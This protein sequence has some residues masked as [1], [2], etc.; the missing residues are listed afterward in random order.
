[1]NARVW[2]PLLIIALALA[3]PVVPFLL[4]GEQFE[5]TVAAWLS[6]EWSAAARFGAIVLVLAV[7]LLLP[8]PS[9]AVSTYGGGILGLWPATLASA[10]GMTIGACIGFAIARLCGP[11]VLPRLAKR[12]DLERLDPFAGE[13]GVLLLLT[14]RP[15]PILAEAAVVLLGALGLPWRRFVP[16]LVASNLVISFAYAALGAWAIEWE[17]LPIAV[18]LS[19]AVPVA[20]TLVVRR[21]LS[22]RDDA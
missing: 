8:I 1:M 6:Q 12:E 14:T 15:L 19:L 3:I 22:R 7:D 5:A 17:A 10:L 20:I 9:S 11:R 4:L 21:S 16:P 2:R 18:G 13:Y